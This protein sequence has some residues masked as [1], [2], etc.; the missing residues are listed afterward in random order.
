MVFVWSS[1]A[2]G[3]GGHGSLWHGQQRVA[4]CARLTVVIT[5]R[6]AR[7]LAARLYGRRGGCGCRGLAGQWAAVACRRIG[8]IVL[9][10]AA[11]ADA[12]DNDRQRD[13]FPLRLLRARGGPV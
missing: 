10:R 2:L 9:H 7:A 4:R 3:G 8:G 6:P 12:R 11:P 5:L 1:S 13:R